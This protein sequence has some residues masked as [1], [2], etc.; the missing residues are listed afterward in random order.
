M[1]SRNS[2]LVSTDASACHLLLGCVRLRSRRLGV[3]H[4]TSLE[5]HPSNYDPSIAVAINTAIRSRRVLGGINEYPS[6][7][8]TRPAK[9]HVTTHRRISARNTY[10]GNV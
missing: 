8:L 2:N 9:E 1:P 5:Q 10:A 3:A 7:S 6:S 4:R